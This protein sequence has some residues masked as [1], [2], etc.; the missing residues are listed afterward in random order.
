MNAMPKR[1]QSHSPP[2]QLV[3]MCIEAATKVIHLYRQMFDSGAINITRGYFQTLFTAGLSLI[4]CCSPEHRNHEI[5]SLKNDTRQALHICAEVLK[6]L[7]KTLI[8]SRPYAHAFDLIQTNFIS[9]E[10]QRGQVGAA[11]SHGNDTRISTS[12]GSPLHAEFPRLGF[13]DTNEVMIDPTLPSMA[14]LDEFAN[15]D[16][17]MSEW[18]PLTSQLVSNMEADVSQYAVGDWM[19]P[20]DASFRPMPSF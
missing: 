1:T 8:D 4:Y 11:A 6:E 3:P 5:L 2:N 19:W 18:D 17:F 12:R 9:E 20:S 13:D 16:W 10:A 7:S 14:N 15:Q